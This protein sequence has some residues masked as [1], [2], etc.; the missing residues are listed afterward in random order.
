MSA[1]LA[2]P[3]LNIFHLGALD[4]G[5]P[6]QSFGII[7]ATGVLIGAALLRRYAEWHGVADEHIRGLTGWIT[8]CGFAGAHLFDVLAYQ[9]KD[10]QSDPLLIIE[11]W[12]GIS[13]Y[14]GFIGGAAGFAFYVWWKRQPVR[15]FADVA[16]VGLL[17]AFTIGRIGCTVV[18]DHVG[19]AVD[20]SKWY[21][22]LAID[23]P[24]DVGNLSAH[25]PMLEGSTIRAWNL[26]MLEF[27]YLVPVCILMLWLAFR[28][29]KRT[30]AGMIAIGTALLYA[31]VRFFLDF[32][33]P[34]DTDPRYFG[35][36]FAQWASIVAFGAA[37]YA[38]SRLLGSG[39][40]AE[41]V[42]TTAREAQRKL[43]Q[44]MLKGDD[45]QEPVAD[46]AAA[47]DDEPEAE[48]AKAEGA[49]TEQG[50]APAKAEA[51][52]K[53]RPKQPAR[54]GRGKKKKR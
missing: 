35:L 4:V 16:I 15:L 51:R 10:V 27:L 21:A 11:V 45:E 41:V 28:S 20:P 19:A 52:A 42:A 14:G 30:N 24:R 54:G 31:P 5:I 33:R 6:I 50:D 22:F 49:K 48:D 3:Y 53:P 23:Y 17:P 29:K 12:K 44:I 7:V 25:Y 9:W 18:S 39:A 13:S 43:K 26:G 32:L 8:V 37:I 40:P 2:L 1:V 36:T 38:A 34:A 46:K 47:D